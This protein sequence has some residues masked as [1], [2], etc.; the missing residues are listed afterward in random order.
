[1]NQ[2]GEYRMARQYPYLTAYGRLTASPIPPP[3]MYSSANVATF[4]R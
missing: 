2:V 1:M 3:A 4:C